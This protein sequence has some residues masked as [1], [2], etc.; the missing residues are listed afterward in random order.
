M[1]GRIILLVAM[2]WLLSPGAA[3]ACDTVDAHAGDK[4]GESPLKTRRPVRGDNVR[5]TSGFGIRFDPVLIE[6]RL[7]AGIDWAA[8]EGTPVIAAAGG[9][10]ISAA[11]SED[12]GRTVAIDHGAGWQTLYAHLSAFDVREGDCVT[13]GTVIGKVGKTG[14]AAG[15]ALHFEVHRDGKPIDPLSEAV[16]VVTP[17]VEGK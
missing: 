4:A 1:Q 7:H 8:P 3:V 9:R 13:F 14:R 5:L 17:V 16:K 12:L 15:P 11:M 10:V 2:T 6:R